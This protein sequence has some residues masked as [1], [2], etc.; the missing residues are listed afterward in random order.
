M[1]TLN[2][3]A[4]ATLN[5][6][7]SMLENGYV[8][9]DNTNGSFM[10]V[11]VEEISNNEHYMILSVAHYFE[12]NGD[13]L[14][15]PEMQ[16]IHNKDLNVYIPFYFKQDNIGLEEE[17]IIIENGEIKGYKIKMQVDHTAFANLWLSNI[18]Q[19]QNL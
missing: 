18:K 7:L 13:L 2:A 4:T 16:F 12:Q 19:Q 17:S 10:P 3:Q 14:A 11:S 9:I 6:L 5:K 8:K 1:K 15:D